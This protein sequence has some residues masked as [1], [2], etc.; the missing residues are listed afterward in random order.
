LAVVLCHLIASAEKVL[1][2]VIKLEQPSFRVVPSR[3]IHRPKRG[4]ADP[5]RLPG[6]CR[7][8]RSQ[9]AVT[10]EPAMLF[11]DLPIRHKLVG[12]ISLISLSALLVAGVV[13]LAY[14]FGKSRRAMASRLSTIA[15]IVSANSSAALI[16][17][18]DGAA[19]ETLSALKAEPEILAAALY[20][21]NGRLFARYPAGMPTNDFPSAPALN[22]PH[23]GDA[24]TLV[25]PVLQSQRPVGKLFLRADYRNLSHRM[26]VY[27]IVLMLVLAGSG[28][29]TLFLSNRFE[30]R[31]SGPLLQLAN[32]ATAVSQKRDYSARA[33]KSGADE[34]GALTDAFNSMLEQIQKSDAALR[35]SEHRF[36]MIADN[37]SVLAWTA[38][39]SGKG[40][41]HN[42]RWYDYTGLS[43]ESPSGERWSRLH[44][45]HLNRVKASWEEACA[46]KTVWEDTFPLR[47]SDGQYRWFLSR[48]VPIADETGNI[49]HWFGTNVD[50]T[51]MREAERSLAHLAAIVES[52]HD[53]II[54]KTLD[55]VIRTWNRGAEQI[56]GFTAAEAVGQPIRMII[57][58]ER[59]FEEESILERQR[60]GESIEHFETVRVRKD[61][62]Q[63]EVSLSI[64]PLRDSR[65]QIVGI[66]KIARD[67]TEKK[68]S[69]RALQSA[70]IAAKAAN[71]AKD[72]FLAALS[73]ELRTPLMPVMFTV[74]GMQQDPG[75]P[76]PVRNSLAVVRRNLEIQVR[77]IN[78]LIDLSRIRANRLELAFEVV[79]LHETLN[80]AFEVCRSHQKFSDLS[81][82]IKLTAQNPYVRADADRM[83]QVF[84][85]L[86]QNAIKFTPS[87]GEI[88][89]RS[90]ESGGN[91]CV[92]VADTGCGIEP[93]VL[94]RI[95]EPFEQGGRKSKESLQGLGLGLAIARRIVTAH[96]GSLTATSGGAGQGA[97]F[98][99]ELQTVSPPSPSSVVAA[100]PYQ[101]ELINQ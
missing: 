94:G 97:T 79:D 76:S 55:G 92:C 9:S 26:F 78:D 54:S 15:R 50:I 70:L 29:L 82:E 77:M 72:D 64:S 93:E 42:K 44:P 63:I 16:S 5:V 84:W 21:Q 88:T 2:S 39:S 20:D 17:N 89:I 73:H 48:A 60:R 41:W 6:G 24:F 69:E 59:H 22:D 98:T 37:I 90:Y 65:G 66:S 53:A 99:L 14:E 62:T 100:F 30:S 87:G 91:F 1:V 85:N 81:V 83:Q 36:R 23:F 80:R 33:T 96:G 47:G 95:F 51:E 4:G 71:R 35:D 57:P 46:Q 19:H 10:R 68:R 58:P 74:S 86:I 43:Q 32:V 12:L 40:N 3:L 101:P 25:I 8:T 13:M 38:D 56:F 45:D 7:W 49:L 18:Q 52:S 75:L 27:G 61:G 67:I 31:I 34:L 28:A 11:R